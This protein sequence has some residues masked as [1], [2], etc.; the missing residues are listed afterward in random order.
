MLIRQKI[1]E[2]TSWVNWNYMGL[3]AGIF[4]VVITLN[5]INVYWKQIEEEKKKK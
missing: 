2:L 5:N 4:S 3:I 1:E